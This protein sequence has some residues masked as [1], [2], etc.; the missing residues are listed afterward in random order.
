MSDKDW[1]YAIHGKQYGPVPAIHIKSMFDEERVNEDTLFWTE[2]MP[3]CLSASE[4]AEI[5]TVETYRKEYPSPSTLSARPCIKSP[6]RK[7]PILAVILGLIFGPF[8]ALYFG[9]KVLLTTLFVV[10]GSTLM[11]S[12]VM[13]SLFPRWFGYA[14]GLFFAVWNHKL[15]LCYNTLL[16]TEDEEFSLATLSLLKMESLYVR[17]LAIFMGLYSGTMLIRDERWFF[18]IGVV[19]FLTPFIIWLFDGAAV[20]MFTFLVGLEERRKMPS[21]QHNSHKQE[22][23]DKCRK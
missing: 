19:F 22:S 20:L 8:S 16:D 15:C 10:F 11:V 5:V 17:F 2:Q 18:A 14:I 3:E 21:N 1:Y 7:S 13:P 23:L 9:W 6:K 12:L 4:M